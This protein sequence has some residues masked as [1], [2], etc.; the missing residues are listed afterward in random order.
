[1]TTNPVLM[2]SFIHCRSKDQATWSSQCPALSE[3]LG[4]SILIHSMSTKCQSSHGL[5][6]CDFSKRINLNREYCIHRNFH[7][8]KFLHGAVRCAL[9][10]PPTTSW[11]VAHALVEIKFGEIFVTIQSMS[12]WRQRKF[13]CIR[14]YS[15]YLLWIQP[16]SSYM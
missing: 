2:D 12:H 9:I 13:P 10:G 7:L 15:S 11:R 4:E 3:I 14:Y 5:V 8:E 6:L 16:L 1:M